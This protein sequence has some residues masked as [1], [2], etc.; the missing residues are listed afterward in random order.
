MQTLS[1]SAKR[2]PIGILSPMKSRL[3]GLLRF[4][5]D[6]GLEVWYLL[7]LYSHR[8][9]NR[10]S[11]L[12]VSMTSYPPRI[13]GSWV[14]LE[15]LFRQNFRDF[16]LVLVLAEPQFPGR[17]LPLIINLMR[18]KGLEILWVPEDNKSWDHLWPAYSNYYGCSVISVDDDK[19]FPRSLVR[20]LVRAS[21]RHPGAIIGARGWE[22]RLEEKV[23]RF[24]K[25]WVRASPS[26]KS[27]ALFMPPG[28]GSLYP[29]GSLPPLSGDTELMRK[30]CPVADDVWY[31]ATSTI[32]GTPNVCL[33]LPPHRPVRV[34]NATVALANEDPGPTEFISA[35]RHFRLQ[36]VLSPLLESAETPVK[37]L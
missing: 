8:L 33:A 16:R 19:V 17:K 21:E 15:S 28:N 6:L 26:T 31:W 29:P 7:T 14:S 4:L 37:G 9:Q 24:K 23:L 32:N 35:L 11:N 27:Q 13:G 30:V 25:G 20:D 22:M 1:R 34:Q 5:Y 36:E 10:E 2:Q 12:V 3:N 18:W